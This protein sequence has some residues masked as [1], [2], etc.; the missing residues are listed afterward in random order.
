[1]TH[2]EFV[3]T[4]Q[5]SCHIDQQQCTTLLTALCR[6]MAQAGVEQV[7]V[8]LKGLG[9]FASH[10][11]PEYISEDPHTGKMTLFPPRISYR[12]QQ[13]DLDS[14]SEL[15][16]RQLADH[17]K[18]DE[19]LTKSFLFA[20]VQ[21]IFE[22]LDHGEE[23]EVKGLGSFRNIVTRQGELQRIAYTPDEQMRTLVNAPFN[24]F[25]PVIIDEGQITNATDIAEEASEGTVPANELLEIEN[26]L[27]EIMNEPAQEENSQ[28]ENTQVEDSMATAQENVD[29]VADCIDAAEKTEVEAEETV[30]VV[31]DS[32]VAAEKTED[33]AEETVE[34]SMIQEQ[35]T[36]SEDSSSDLPE[37]DAHESTDQEIAETVPEESKVEDDEPSTTSGVTVD[38]SA[39]AIPDDSTVSN[40]IDN[41]LS[42]GNNMIDAA[43]TTAN[44]NSKHPRTNN[45]L[46]VLC[47][48]LVVSCIALGWFIYNIFSHNNDNFDHVDNS[49]IA[50]ADNTTPE[51]IIV[52]DSISQ[53]TIE[54]DFRPVEVA[55]DSKQD[56][57][58][59][60]KRV[61]V[62]DELPSNVTSRQPV[63]TPPVTTSEVSPTATATTKTPPATNP[64]DPKEKTCMKNA[65]GSLATYT[66]QPGDRLTLIALNYYGSKWFWP[67]IYEVNRNK[68]KSPDVISVGTVLYL[69]DPKYFGLDAND[70]ESIQRAKVKAVKV[71]K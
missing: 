1:M 51:P 38:M 15:L 47:C 26:T 63:S 57:L 4:V 3:T 54:A 8:T 13:E 24:C 16:E 60:E 67:Y 50:A 23:V 18:T 48:I 30:E 9:T 53:D 43:K 20:M 62:L 68:I 11:H 71:S 27:E 6:M 34:T 25:E 49:V 32:I 37:E 44:N 55:N 41:S 21:A 40:E 45:L 33:E 58:T 12:M 66:L 36:V 31:E 19:D 69:P 2:K 14:Q 28:E 29:V 46:K 42:Q 7:P 5:K 22:A 70:P 17:T 10:K 35:D 61:E 52:S 39:Q 65:D 59:P 56:S 64:N